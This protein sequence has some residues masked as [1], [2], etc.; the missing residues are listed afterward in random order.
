MAKKIETNVFRPYTVNTNYTSGQE[1]VNDKILGGISYDSAFDFLDTFNDSEWST[2]RPLMELTVQSDSLTLDSSE[3]SLRRVRTWETV[4]LHQ[5]WKS[6]KHRLLN[7]DHP[8]LNDLRSDHEVTGF[9][10]TISDSA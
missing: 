3:Q 9:M 4:D 6:L 7:V 2:M 5:T 10:E 1:F 8:Y